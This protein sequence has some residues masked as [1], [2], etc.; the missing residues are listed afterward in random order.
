MEK[1]ITLLGALFIVFNVLGLMTAAVVFIVLIGGGLL[2]GDSEPLFITSTVGTIIAFFLTIVSIPGLICGFGLLKK[3][4]W[5]RILGIVLGF[6][7]LI[8]IP[9]GTCLG[10]YTLWALMNKDA[11]ALFTGT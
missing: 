9:L 7:L 5:S 4:T 10:I 2:S 8:H 6:I 11:E 1:H 3:S